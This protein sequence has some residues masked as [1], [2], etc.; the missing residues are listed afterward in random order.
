MTDSVVNTEVYHVPVMGPQC[1]EG[2]NIKPEGVYADVTFGGGGHSKL[3][4]NESGFKGSLFAFDK[5]DDA[6]A[7]IIP[8]PRFHFFKTDF[9]YFH[10]FLRLEGYDKIDGILADLGVSSHHFD[11]PE[12]GFSFRFD[13]P[14]DMRM[15]QSDKFSA[16]D[17][18]N[19]YPAE[20]LSAVFKE[21]GEIN[22][23]YR[24][25]LEIVNYRNNFSMKTV[26]DLL[27]AAQKCMPLHKEN[28][29]SAMMF[30]ALRIEVNGEIDTL[31]DFL[32]AAAD[33]LKPGGRLVIMTY[34]SLEDR[35]VK[36]FI[37]TGNFSAERITDVY[38]NVLAPFVQ[39]NRKVIEPDEE[40]LQRNPRS[41]S[42]KL[43]IAERTSY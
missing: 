37:K 39:I 26:G 29:Y 20:K 22:N 12:R 42:A 11:T 33:A 21:Y 18:L 9:K 41:R 3:I 15:N 40:E 19:S 13:A 16:C 38:G 28:R 17:L 43:R 24:L 5:D 14:L 23:A 25:A 1:I 31:K 7:N 35:P 27:K 32:S 2:L 30:Q 10:N 6:R 34:H 4:L 8:D 36:N